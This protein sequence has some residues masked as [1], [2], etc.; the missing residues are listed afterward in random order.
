[1]TH[2]QF[3][4]ELEKLNA[5]CGHNHEPKIYNGYVQ[6]Q[7]DWC[8]EWAELVATQRDWWRRIGKRQASYP[9]YLDNVQELSDGPSIH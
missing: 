2:E 1:M 3:F 4:K 9:Q 6:Y 8:K 5:S 7:S